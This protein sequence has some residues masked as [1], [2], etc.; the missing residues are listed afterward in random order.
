MKKNPDFANMKFEDSFPE[1]KFDQWQ[2]LA[3]QYSGK[4]LASIG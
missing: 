4:S 1:I 2:K 3:E